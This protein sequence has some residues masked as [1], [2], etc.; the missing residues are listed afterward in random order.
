MNPEVLV[1]GAGLGG[2]SCAVELARQG[3][4]VLVLEAAPLPGGCLRTFRKRGHHFHLSPQYIGALQ[5]GGAADAV[6]ASMGVRDQLRLHR[7]PIFL[8]AELPELQLQL[9]NDREGL[10]EVLLQTFPRER[11]GIVSL[12]AAVEEL[13]SA[14][15][16]SSLFPAQ[17][18]GARRALLDA[19]RGRSFQS[20]LAE[21]VV[22]PR[23]H[24]LLG[25]T[26]MNMG[27]PP[28]Q[29]AAP[30]AATVFASGWLD[31]VNTIVGGGTALVRTLHDRLIELG[32]E[33]QLSAPVS[34]II[35]DKGSVSGVVLADGTAVDCPLVVA[36]ID[37]IQVFFELIPGPEVSRLFRFRLERMEPSISMYTLHL[38]LDCPPSQLGVAGSTTFVNTQLDHDEAY[39]RA[40]EGE[41]HHSSWRLTSYEG[42]H[43]ECFPTGGGIVAMT[44]VTP[45]GSWLEL[46]RPQ[47]AELESHV[48]ET[49]MAKAERRYPSLTAHT[50][51]R[52]IAT[53]R[54]L[55][56]LFRNHH[57]AA[58]GLAQTPDQSGRSRLGARAP[59]AGLFLAG[60]WTRAGGGVEATM[61]GG[62]QAAS[63]AMIY[64]DR[65]V[66]APA[67]QLR[68]RSEQRAESAQPDIPPGLAWP[69][70]P[71]TLGEQ[72]DHRHMSMVY[73]CDLNARGY[74]DV[75]AYLRFMD[76]AR[77]EAIETIC[78]ARGEPSWHDSHV[79]NVYRVQARF[80]TVAGLGAR[81]QVRTGL[82][83]VSTHRGA[84]RQRIV[85]PKR[86]RLLLDG[87]VEVAFLD[88]DG[89]MVP[90]PP[91]MPTTTHP[92]DP[93]FDASLRLPP[94]SAHEWFPFRSRTRVHFEDTDLQGITFHVSYMRFAERALFDLVRTVWPAL[95]LSD[96]MQ[97]YR[98]SV[99]GIDLRF[100]RPT[101]LG[102]RIDVWTGV[103]DVSP[104]QLAFGQRFML[105]D[106]DELTADLVTLVEFRDD[107]ERVIELPRQAA[108]IARANLLRMKRS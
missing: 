65:P 73:G 81:L 92:P 21:H 75:E 11:R 39:R 29:A 33:C 19:W 4:K 37:P 24:T 90:V 84:F 98:V 15:V 31:G 70:E 79:V 3:V 27:L 95:G 22:D 103:L 63:A 34:R 36:A 2:L 107:R 49:L 6:L 102:D 54:T 46:D 28:S 72:L 20:L 50:V 71:A 35:I 101:R 14:V 41:L 106:T 1:I 8:T 83:A 60:A 51:Q 40:V 78:K 67:A 23:L 85:D 9:P 80:A 45:P 64:A 58:Y 108:D 16:E 61:M 69:D 77:T 32:G 26:W 88:H 48:V 82:G 44:E 99:C 76:R 38:G 96:W 104:Q 91:A 47:Q 87:R 30:F 5:P 25:Q 43:D 86:K 7:P 89:R 17:N 42:S 105:A 59:V 55:R 94:L 18:Q 12:F 74:A 57:G 100:L 62:V 68:L 52:E 93:A 13:S 97:T 53:P 56:D 66:I 10:L